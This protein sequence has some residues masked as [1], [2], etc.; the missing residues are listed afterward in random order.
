[1]P[2]DDDSRNISVRLPA[3]T[4]RALM[5]HQRRLEKKIGGVDLS[6]SA[7]VRRIIE[8]KLNVKVTPA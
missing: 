2:D 5:E 3:E 1:M 7:V 6:I 4:Y 8:E